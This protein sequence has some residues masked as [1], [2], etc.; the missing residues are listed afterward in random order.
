MTAWIGRLRVGESSEGDGYRT[1][2]V[3]SLRKALYVLH[4][5]IKKSESGIGLPKRDAELT[6]AR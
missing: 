3:V 4:A 6:A 5:F 2:Y 1:M